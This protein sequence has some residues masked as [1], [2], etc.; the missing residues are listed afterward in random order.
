VETKLYVGNLPFS[1]TEE[2]LRELFSEAGIVVSVRVVRD[3]ESGRSKGF[4]FV[5]MSRQVDVEAALR[6]FNNYP[7][8]GRMLKVSLAR[9][10]EKRETFESV[11]D[12]KY[13]DRRRWERKHRKKRNN[14]SD[15]W[16][17]Y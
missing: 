1:M 17:D 5:Q 4:G 14:R 15:D 9:R 2:K 10:P 12:G 16:E 3:E 6:K 8:D 13:D 11:Y 7:L